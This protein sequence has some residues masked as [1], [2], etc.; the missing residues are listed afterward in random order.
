MRA[1]AV[2]VKTTTSVTM[3]P[4]DKQ[5]SSPAVVDAIHAQMDLEPDLVHVL[6]L[7][8]LLT[9]S[10]ASTVPVAEV[11]VPASDDEA[12]PESLAS[13]EA[14]IDS[15]S[16]GAHLLQESQR[17][18][19]P[20]T[21]RQ[22]HQQPSSSSS[23]SMYS[24]SSASPG[25]GSSL[26]SSAPTEE[27]VEGAGVTVTVNMAVPSGAGVPPSAPV[28]GEQKQAPASPTTTLPA[29]ATVKKEKL[30]ES[31]RETFVEVKR[32][33]SMVKNLKVEMMTIEDWQ[34]NIV[35][36]AAAPAARKAATT[37][38]ASSEKTIPQRDETEAQ[39]ERLKE[40]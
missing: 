1:S 27:K 38:T 34:S 4:K 3:S 8:E 14:F 5:F 25:D 12:D 24:F 35:A 37:A 39:Q 9:S 31:K 16:L 13:M 19:R 36:Q 40:K 17:M 30:V 22:Q 18:K 32:E 7:Q 21:L 10:S 15:R 33:V 20:T 23:D 26:A 2:V 11:A 28:T 6:E 29:T